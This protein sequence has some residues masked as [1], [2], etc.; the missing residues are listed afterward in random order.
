MAA[1]YERTA[2]DL[3]RNQMP[4]H[5]GFWRM[6]IGQLPVSYNEKRTS[7][8]QPFTTP[9]PE[10]VNGL[11]QN[12]ICPGLSATFAKESHYKF[13]TNI[14]TT[15]DNQYE[16]VI[17]VTMLCDNRYE[18]YWAIDRYMTTVQSG[19]TNGEPIEN[20][21]H[22]VYGIDKRY[23]N[24]LTYIPYIDIHAADDVAQE[25]MIFRFERCRIA[26]LSDL[27]VKPGAIDVVSFNLSIKYEI[28]RLI[29]LPDPNE[30]MTAICVTTS[31][32]AYN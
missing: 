30:L 9:A 5:Q 6:R 24:R 28:R 2:R 13:V 20:V 31:S 23:R 16:K 10:T 17:T 29:R 21:Y 22:P 12:F 19:Q 11:I 8:T 15:E 32:N 25:Y 18:N 7:V 4:V 1:D 3:T 27:N 14:P 26:E